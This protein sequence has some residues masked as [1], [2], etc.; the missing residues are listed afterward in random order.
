MA[1]QSYSPSSKGNFSMVTTEIRTPALEVGKKA[2]VP[3]LTPRVIKYRVSVCFT[4]LKKKAWYDCYKP[5]DVHDNCDKHVE[6]CDQCDK[7]VRVCNDCE[8]R[9]NVCDICDTLTCAM[10]LKTVLTSVMTVTNM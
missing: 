9:V 10:T 6:V 8:R 4:L 3:T 5:V 1:Y 2:D 7:R